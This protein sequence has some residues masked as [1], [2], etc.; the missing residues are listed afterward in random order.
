M[1]AAA[2]I[3]LVGSIITVASKAVE[4]GQDVTPFAEA[5]YNDLINKKTISAADLATL[6]QKIADLEAKAL[7][8]LDPELP[9]EL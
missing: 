6:E 8:P 9:D 5:I 2:I 1:D 7:A 4:L 3:A